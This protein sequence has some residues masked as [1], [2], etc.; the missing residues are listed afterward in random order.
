MNTLPGLLPL[1]LR[2]TLHDVPILQLLHCWYSYYCNCV[3]T[4][5]LLFYSVLYCELRVHY[6]LYIKHMCLRNYCNCWLIELGLYYYY[7]Y[8]YYYYCVSN[9]LLLCDNLSI[10]ILFSVQVRLTLE[11]AGVGG[12]GVDP[13]MSRPRAVPQV[14]QLVRLL[15]GE[16]TMELQM[17][18]AHIPHI[19]MYLSLKLDS[20]SSQEEVSHHIWRRVLLVTVRR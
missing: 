2:H 14:S 17:S 16:D 20:E 15:W 12:G 7:Y 9:L 6:N 5:F 19:V 3:T 11:T 18:V 4:S 1:S 13:A 10:S 8:C